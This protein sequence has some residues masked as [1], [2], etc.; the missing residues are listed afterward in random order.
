MMKRYFLSG[1]LFL[2]VVF[3]AVFVTVVPTFF[4]KGVSRVT[5]DQEIKLDKVLSSHNDIEFV[6]F[7]YAG[8]LD[9][10]T[11]RLQQLGTWFALL[12]KSIQKRVG[13][14]FLDLSVP[15]DTSVPDTFAKTFHQEFTGEYLSQEVLRRYTKA[16][17]V[18]FANS[19]ARKDEIDHSANLYLI[20]RYNTSKKIRFIY[21]AYPY[22]FK[23]IMSDVKELINE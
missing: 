20:K 6:F 23:Q 2:L 1:S 21:T 12:P 18:Y 8:C 15:L 3:I 7:G 14:R 9:V 5:L 10:C 11:P 13:V 22:D 17:N 16:F 4:T 19:L